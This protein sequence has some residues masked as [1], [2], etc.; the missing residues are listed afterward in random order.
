MAI[1]G[2]WNSV[3]TASDIEVECESLAGNGQ[4]GDTTCSESDSERPK[5]RGSSR[6]ALLTLLIFFSWWCIITNPAKLVFRFKRS[7]YLIRPLQQHVP[8]FFS[9][10]NTMFVPKCVREAW[11]RNYPPNHGRNN[12]WKPYVSNISVFIYNLL[13]L[14]DVYPAFEESLI[15]T[16]RKGNFLE[17]SEK[18]TP[19][20]FTKC[21]KNAMQMSM[22]VS[23]S[24]S[25]NSSLIQNWKPVHYLIPKSRHYW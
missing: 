6:A 23:P 16:I 5:K 7:N 2:P 21:E 19:K 18:I 15:K 13:H 9:S 10:F 20:A 3:M 22:L 1:E 25:H 24:Y 8:Y 14:T 17:I 12:F 4:D 11:D